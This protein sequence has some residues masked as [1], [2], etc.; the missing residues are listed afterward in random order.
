MAYRSRLPRTKESIS[1]DECDRRALNFLSRLSDKGPLQ[2]A[3]PSEVANA[4]WPENSMHAQGAGLAG[5]RIL[6]RL[7]DRG[8]AKWTYADVGR[9]RSDGWV[10]TEAGRKAIR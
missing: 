1:T 4:V 6:R 3:R 10:I 2:F 7:A 8:L 9:F 5:A